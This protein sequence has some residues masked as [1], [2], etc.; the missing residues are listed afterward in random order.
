MPVPEAYFQFVM[1]Y[2]PYLYVT[3]SVGPDLTWGKA[4]F[5][6]GFSVDFLYEAYFDPQFEARSND[7]EAKI[8]ELCDWTITQQVTDQ[9]AQA[10]GGFLSTQTSTACYSVDACRTAPALLKAYELT[11]NT[12]YLNSAKLAVG[13]F[14]FNM[15]HAPSTLGIHDRYYGG[16]ARAVDTEDVWQGQMD[17]ECLYGLS[18]LGMLSES[19]P[20]DQ[21]KYQTMVQDA[22]NFY[23]PGVEELELFFDPSPSG[24]GK[25]HRTGL[26]DDTVYDDSIAYALLGLYD[27]EGYS[28][29]VRKAYEAMN[30]AAPAQY[31]AYNP[32]IAWAGYVNAQKNTV[33]CDYYDAVSAGI[34]SKIRRAHDKLAYDFSA[35][36][37]NAHPE[38]FMFWGVK[39]ADWSAVENKQAMATVSWVGQHLLDYEPPLTRFIQVLNSKGENFTLF[40]IVEAGEDAAY[41]EGFDFKGIVLAGKAEEILLEPGYIFN[42]Y[43]VLHVF[44]PLRRQDKVRRNGVDYEVIAVQDFT[45]QNQ[46]AFKKATC[47]RMR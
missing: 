32:A 27:Y 38:E 23:R 1:D 11:S 45:F 35:K 15:Q 26:G 33:A 25:W 40:P 13:T 12:L 37:I 34:L 44:T 42:D 39:H 14:L 41:G 28:G 31:A 30:A 46:V 3:P 9:D 36:T 18:A 47:R 43:I 20:A 22:V 19:D 17:V 21:S 24:D 16:F 4:A 6:A 5:A 8:T 2:A 29:T 7:I 10:Y